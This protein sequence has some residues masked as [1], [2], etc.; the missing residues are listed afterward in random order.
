MNLA[1]LAAASGKFKDDIHEVGL[2][3]TNAEDVMMTSVADIKD[4]QAKLA[5]VSAQQLTDIHTEIDSRSTVLAAEGRQFSQRL[6]KLG[7]RL[8]ESDKKIEEMYVG[9]IV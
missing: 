9:L 4:V 1:G 2:T 3:P 5:G 6:E 7:G 8:G